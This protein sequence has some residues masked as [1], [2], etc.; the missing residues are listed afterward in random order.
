[1]KGSFIKWNLNSE[2]LS[3]IKNDY[4]NGPQRS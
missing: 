2:I 4:E 3:I 1:M